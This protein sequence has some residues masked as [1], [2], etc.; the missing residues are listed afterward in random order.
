MQKQDQSRIH[1]L[2]YEIFNM[3]KPISVI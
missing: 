1:K 2:F 3:V